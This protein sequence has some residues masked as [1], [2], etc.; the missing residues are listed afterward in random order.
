MCESISAGMFPSVRGLSTQSVQFVESVTLAIK[1][2][3]V[4]RFMSR[5][6]FSIGHTYGRQSLHGLL[7]S[8][9]VHIS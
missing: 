2:I 1:V 3:L 9:G 6:V 8:E 7:R 5:C 4:D